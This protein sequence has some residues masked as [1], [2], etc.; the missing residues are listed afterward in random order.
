M[1]QSRPALRQ[2][3]GADAR[4]AGRSRSGPEPRGA[5]DA[6]AFIVMSLA[7]RKLITIIAPESGEETPLVAWIADVEA[8]P[9]TK[10]A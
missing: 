10:F 7:K 9:A 1:L 5:R 6:W 2:R 8:F 4:A 3:P